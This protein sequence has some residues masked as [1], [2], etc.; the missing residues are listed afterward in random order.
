MAVKIMIYCIYEYAF[1]ENISDIKA[2]LE[3]KFRHRQ[4]RACY[5]FSKDINMKKCPNSHGFLR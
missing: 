1:M 3:I 5:T 4:L 2:T